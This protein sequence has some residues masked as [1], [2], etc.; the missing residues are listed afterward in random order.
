MAESV[1]GLARRAGL[2]GERAATLLLR[3]E[4]G[5]NS[6]QPWPSYVAGEH[7]PFRGAD[8]WRKP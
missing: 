4:P 6:Y 1:S 7:F 5:V 2:A 3:G 8:H